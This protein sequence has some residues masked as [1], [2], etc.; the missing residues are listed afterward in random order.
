MNRISFQVTK[1]LPIRLISLIQ[2]D[3]ESQQRNVREVRGR[4]YDDSLFENDC[5]ESN[6]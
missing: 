3:L 4:S 5:P 1:I 6:S 2:P